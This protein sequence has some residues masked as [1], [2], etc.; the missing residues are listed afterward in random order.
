MLMRRAYEQF[1][2]LSTLKPMSVCANK[3]DIVVASI[4][5]VV[6]VVVLIIIVTKWLW[7]LSLKQQPIK[8]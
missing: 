2:R 4:V 5:V 1:L 8:H 6:V 3:Y 7:I